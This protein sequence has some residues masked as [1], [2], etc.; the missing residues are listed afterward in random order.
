MHRKTK[1]IKRKYKRH[2]FTLKSRKGKGG[3]FSCMDKPKS[4]QKKG[5][6]KIVSAPTNIYRENSQKSSSSNDYGQFVITDT[7]NN[8]PQ[9]LVNELFP[10]KRQTKKR[11]VKTL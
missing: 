1:N 5:S 11:G 7:N 10:K 9:T 6:K 3:I 2:R 8:P 4:S